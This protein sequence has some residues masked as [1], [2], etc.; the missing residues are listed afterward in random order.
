MNWPNEILSLSAE[1]NHLREEMDELKAY[2]QSYHKLRKNI[3]IPLEY[4]S[5]IYDKQDFC[6]RRI[7]LLKQELWL[8]EEA[9][10]E[11]VVIFQKDGNINTVKKFLK[12]A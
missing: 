5:K 12:S 9:L 4:R 10:T 8:T 1:A 11:L 6:I 3:Y 7:E 2:V